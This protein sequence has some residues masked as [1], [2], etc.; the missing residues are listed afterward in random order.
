MKNIKEIR[1]PTTGKWLEQQI[2]D[3]INKKGFVF[4]TKN[5]HRFVSLKVKAHKSLMRFLKQNQPRIIM[6]Y[7]KGIILTLMQRW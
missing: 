1:H 7:I 6:V 2:N 4:V 3:I 5:Q